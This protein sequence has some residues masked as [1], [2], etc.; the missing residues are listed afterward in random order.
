MAQQAFGD[1]GSVRRGT[2][3]RREE[4]KIEAGQEQE[5]GR[6][7]YGDVS[8]EMRTLHVPFF[9]AR[10]PSWRLAPAKNPAAEYTKTADPD[11]RF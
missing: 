7:D 4:S 3:R 1:G 11:N 8:P 2:V 10:L 5:L 9:P 6:Q